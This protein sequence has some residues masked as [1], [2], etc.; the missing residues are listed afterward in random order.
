MSGSS[1][2]TQKN[3]VSIPDFFK[4][5]YNQGLQG[6]QNLFQSGSLSP[7]VGMSDSTRK[8]LDSNLSLADFLSNE[9]LPGAN[10]SFMSLLNSNLTESPQLQ[11]VIQSATRPIQQNLERYAIPSTQDAAISAGQLGSSRQGVAEGLARSDANRQMG[12]IGSQLSYQALL[13][14][15][16]N[17]QFGISNLN[18]FI[19]ALQTPAN[20]QTGVGGIEEGYEQEAA[21]APA[22]NLLK[23][24]QILQ[25][26]NPGVNTT[27]TQT[28]SMSNFQKLAALGSLATSGYKAYKEA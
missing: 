1:K 4:P 21:N 18:N 5:Y 26:L 7:V 8:G 9:T 24:I 16:Q 10:T 20:L 19:A 6:A 25:G 12:D 15:Q 27:S 23:Y 11:S 17:K 13:Q 28:S 22:N 14:D 3:E 2:Q